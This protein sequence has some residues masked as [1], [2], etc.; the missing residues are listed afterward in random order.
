M[1]RKKLASMLWTVGAAALSETAAAATLDLYVD[2]KTQRIFAEPGP[3]RVK[4]GTVMQVDE[5]AGAAPTTQN[6]PV[7]AVPSSA[8][9]AAP[10]AE[11]KPAKPAEKKWYDR[12]ALRGYTQLRYNQGLGGDAADLRSPGDRFIGDNQ[13]FGIRRARVVISGDLNDRVS[14]Y[15]QPD[16][17]STPTGSTT[18]NFAQLR[19][20]YA[21]IY[22]DKNREFRVRA[23]QS[24][25]P[26][27]WENLQSSQNRL[28]PDR[29]DALNSG[30]RD[31][32]DLGLFFYYTPKHV[33][34][35]FQYLV[36]S[37]LKGS[38][39]YGVLGLGF[40]NGQGA[41]RAEQNN[42]LHT[43]L[44]FSY[45]FKFANG[46]FFEVG[47]DAYSGR[48]KIAAPG[49]ITVDGRSFTPKDTAPVNGSIDQRVAVHA[50]YYPQP[51][52]LQAEWTVGRGPELDLSRRQIRTKSLRGGYVQAMYKIDGGSI[53][54]LFP[55]LKWQ[56]YRGASKFDTNTP[57]MLVDE[58]EVGV[59]WQPNNAVELAVAYANMRRTNVSSAPY[60]RIDGDLLRVQLQVNY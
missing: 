48:F 1:K 44:H 50:I 9:A 17:A 39:D 37:G 28:T 49:S 54:T 24:K 58:T 16:F 51:F 3:G 2:R 11:A 60:R 32:R 21:D 57:R 41:N 53:G 20:A 45:P 36:K 46:Q 33:Q 26:Y 5:T 31:E 19:D 47:A 25:V 35:R 42:S 30:V 12:I 15:L 18:S 7:A 55:Y 27:G 34:E 22:F 29:A 10:A 8:I 43:V 59:E 6:V 14:I 56:T 23:G 52:G 40:Y 4:L 13:G 38:G